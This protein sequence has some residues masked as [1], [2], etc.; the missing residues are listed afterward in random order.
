MTTE[1]L[2][3]RLDVDLKEAM[4]S[5]D[6]KK[7]GAIRL[8]KASVI[9]AEKNSPDGID[10]IKVLQSEVKKRQQAADAYKLGAAEEREAQEL[11]EKDV[12]E[13]YL[14]KKQAEDET[15][16]ILGR[17][18]A[19]LSLSSQ[20]DMGRLIKEFQTRYPGMQDGATVSRLA[21]ALLT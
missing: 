21:K 5:K 19:D 4:K 10:W 9:T 20:K 14:P 8:V 1:E 15:N 18:K 3:Q 13:A 7:T 6:Q 2:K 11:Y 12:I 17:I 16:T